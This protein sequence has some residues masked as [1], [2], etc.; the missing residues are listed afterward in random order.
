MSRTFD[1]TVTLSPD[2]PSWPGE[3]APAI[4]RLYA[5]DRGDVA[6]VTR[7]AG[8]VHAGTHVD[9]PLHFIDGGADVAALELDVL[10]GPARLVHL[11]DADV[12]S[13]EILDRLDLAPGTERLLFRTRNSALWDDPGHAFR[14]DYV[15]L[16]PDAAR[17]VVARGIRLVGVDY[18]S[19]ERF[20]E[21]GNATHR[22]LLG[23]AVVIVEGLDLRRVPEGDYQ[24]VCLPL[25][26]AGGDG[27]PARVVLIEPSG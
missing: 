24:L 7:M 1:V 13:T 15:A 10:M 8:P 18:L 22:I 11:P 4:D 17:W 23:A 6:N 2:M 26:I 16:T 21:P 12:V 20:D 14:Q 9:A 5:L 27:A 19:V 3:P 25:K